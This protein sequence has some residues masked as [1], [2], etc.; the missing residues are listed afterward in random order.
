MDKATLEAK[1]K[2]VNNL[3]NAIAWRDQQEHIFRTV[4]VEYE[5]TCDVPSEGYV[6]PK[7]FTICEKQALELLQTMIDAN[8]KLIEELTVELK[9]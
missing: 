9:A 1:Q 3:R 6:L 8:N 7:R 2:V 5:L 4:N